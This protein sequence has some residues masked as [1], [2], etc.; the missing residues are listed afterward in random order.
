M[1]DMLYWMGVI[2]ASILAVIVVFVLVYFYWLQD[3][4]M[5]RKA[6]EEI[7]EYVHRYKGRCTGGSN[8]FLVN[9]EV[10]QGIF[11][12]YDTETIHKVWLELV[13]QR[14]VEQ[15]PLDHTWCVR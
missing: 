4:L 2:A 12:E 15:D 9:V 5:Y 8:R 11:V 7:F 1:M 10:L 6:K 3:W 14:I 13:D